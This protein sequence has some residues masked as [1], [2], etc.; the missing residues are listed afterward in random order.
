[1]D[2]KRAYAKSQYA[3]PYESYCRELYP[4]E[5]EEIFGK[6]ETYYLEFMKE[7]PDLGKN[8]MAKNML[9]WF[10][11]LSFYEASKHR[12]D[13]EALLEIKRR[14]ADKMGFLGKLVDGNRRKWPYR[15][16]EKIYVKYD[17][18]LKKHQ[19]KGKWM[20]A[21]KVEINPDH[22]TEGFAFHLIG[23]PIA[24]HAKEHGYE[25]LLPYLCKTDHYLAGVM[26]ARLIRT[27]TEALGGSCCDYWYVGD[28]SP[29][30]EKYK[31][32]KQI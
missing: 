19:A 31:D 4:D 25:A 30:L 18:A 5:A 21:W 13:G 28:K 16:F 20:D 11:I 26:H 14:T 15:L 2:M 8:M 32:L 24:K 29:V 17:K 9:D 22:R 12:L 3:K 23:C 7:M 1:M 27:Q 6:A 10:T